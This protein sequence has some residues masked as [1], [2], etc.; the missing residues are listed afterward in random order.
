V[1]TALERWTAELVLDAHARLGEG[2]VWSAAEAVL[3]WVDIDLGR[4]HR[5]DPATGRD[6]HL[7]VGESVGAVAPRRTGG[8]VLALQTG[9]GLADAWPQLP[10]ARIGVEE[11]RTDTR[12]NDGACDTGGRFWAGTMHASAEPGHGSLYRLDP[13]GTV[14]HMLGGVSIS[15]GVA[16]SPDDSTMYYVDTPTGGVDA[17][18]FDAASGTIA[19]RRRLI[20][21]DPADGAPDGLVVDA[22]GCLWV[23]LWDGWAAQRYTPDGRLVGV[24]DVPVAR[25]T[26]CA[27]GGAGLDELYITTASPDA[28]DAEQP[29]AGGLFGVRPGVV[30]LHATPFAG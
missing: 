4:V 24:V 28:P 30:G 2:P 7:D 26:K 13:D 25:V 21:V 1:T 5:Y 22:E 11:D 17:F 3:Y 20:D 14:E 23:A 9:F 16:W 15:N 29:N 18:D 8:L 27:F 10:R 12:M 6:D 19:N